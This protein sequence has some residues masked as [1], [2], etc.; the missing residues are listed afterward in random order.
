[1]IY[2]LQNWNKLKRGYKF[3]QKTSYTQ[4]HLGLDVIAVKGTPIYAWQDLEITKF[5]VGVD[6]GNTI[7]IRCK[8]NK[9]L[10]RIMHLNEPVKTGKYKEGE[11]IGYIGSTGRLSTGPHA[12]IDISK[13]GTLNLQNINNFE[14]PE[15]YFLEINK[16]PKNLIK[17]TDISQLKDLKE[18]YLVR[19]G[20]DIYTTLQKLNSPEE[21]KC[22]TEKDIVRIGKTIYK[23]LK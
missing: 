15:A 22:L 1:M 17:I 13:D 23:R 9:R 4:F 12:H 5:L 11:I 3:K 14:D 16:P 19:A 18:E 8:N 20:G 6:G 10:F 21:L 2:P 7:W